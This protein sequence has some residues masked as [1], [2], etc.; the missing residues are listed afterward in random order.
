MPDPLICQVIECELPSD[1]AYS[2]QAALPIP[3]PVVP[4]IPG[5]IL[6]LDVSTDPFAPE[7]SW[8]QSSVPNTN[9]IWRN[10]NGAG[11]VFLASQAGNLTFYNDADSLVLG[12]Y[13]TYKVVPS[14]GTESNQVDVEYDFLL[15][16]TAVSYPTLVVAYGVLQFDDV[17]LVTSVNLP[18]LKHVEGDAYFDLSFVLPSLTM[19]KLVTVGGDFVTT[20]SEIITL[21]L[22]LLTSAGGLT[23]DSCPSLTTVSLPSLTT[24]A[25]DIHFDSCTALTTVSMPVIVFQNGQ[26]IFFDNCALNVASV[27]HILAR[28]VASGVTSASFFLDGGTSAAPSGQ[29][30]TDA[31]ALIAAG[32]TVLHN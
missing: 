4:V 30:A 22:P 9:T 6:V 31:A 25:G 16:G 18:A 17:T 1:Y 3:E 27:N 14:S 26:S 15:L 12:D 7:L 8:S 24:V 10:Q 13:W 21:S 20:F 29:G 28:G 23:C 5:A 32:N 19:P 2:E 11:F